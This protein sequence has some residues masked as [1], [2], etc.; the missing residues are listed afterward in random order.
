MH[1]LFQ[2]IRYSSRTCLRN[3]GFTAI[4]VATLALGIGANTTVFSFVYGMLLKPLGYPDEDRLVYVCSAKPAMGWQRS[5][6]SIPDYVDWREQNA[7]FVDMGVYGGSSRTI[8]GVDRPQRLNVILA[9]ASLLPVLGIDPMLGR[10]FNQEEDRPGA[11]PV[12][13][14]SD[15]FWQRRFGADPEIVGQTILLDGVATTVLGVLPKQLEKAWGA[16]DVWAPFAF[17]VSDY[18][19]GG[20]S[21]FV[22]G[23]LKP[24]ITVREAQAELEAIAA[25]LATLYPESNQG[26]TAEVMPI[27]DYIIEPEASVAVTAMMILVVLVLLIACAN[28]ANLLLAR[29]N[30]RRKEFA[31]RSAVGAGTWRLVRQLITECALLA[32]AG[33]VLGVLLAIWGVEFLI[34]VFP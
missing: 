18:G 29:A 5:T 1:S 7:S 33:G 28:V 24:G 19:R 9:S 22:I 2:D 27:I 11:P 26:W 6:V 20:H 14:L 8:T 4:V 21:Y 3:P 12:A 23:R 16:F 17:D 10:A 32:I 25:R 30:V 31:V 15:G 13:L 34:A